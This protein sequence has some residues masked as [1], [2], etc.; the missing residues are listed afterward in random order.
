MPGYI[1]KLPLPIN[2]IPQGLKDVLSDEK[3]DNPKKEVVVTHRYERE[4]Y[5]DNHEC[6]QMIMAV[7][8]EEDSEN[9]SILRES[10]NGVVAYSV[11]DCRVKGGARE[12]N[13]SVSGNGYIVA[14][15]GDGLHYSFFLAEDVWMILGLKPRLIGDSGQK[16]IFDNPS[17]P[18]YGVVQGD[19]SSEYYFGSNK[20]IK[21]TMQNEYLRKYLWMKGCVGARAFYYEKYIQRTT[22]VVELLAGTEHYKFQEPWI[23]LDIVDQGDR[24]IMQVWGT[25]QS[26]QPELCEE[27]DIDSLTWPGHT[28]P[29]T[30]AKASDIRLREF[31]YIDDSFLT[32]YEK[33]NSFDAIPYYD[34]TSYRIDPSYGGQWSFRD[35]IRIGRNIVRIPFY[36]L[37][38][39]IPDKE[40]YHVYDYAVDPSV[41]DAEKEKEEHTVSKTYRFLE[42]LIKLNE[43]LVLLG[44]VVGVALSES[45]ISEFNRQDFEAE[46]LQKYP[47][48]QK[49]SH[50][51]RRDMQE[52]DF[53]SRC[54]T[55]NEILNKIKV[56]NLKKLLVAMGIA[57]KEINNFQALK[58]LQGILNFSEALLEYGED[59]SAFSYASNFSDLNTRNEKLASLFINNDL[60]NAEAHEA[61]NKSIEHLANIGFDS[62]TLKSGYS[63]ALDFV[64]DS[65]IDSLSYLN[66]KLKGALSNQ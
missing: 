46:G 49:L 55:I 57:K 24:V 38:R 66:Y 2:Q 3:V 31:A 21:W 63:Q 36:E 42:E 39:G 29:M 23:E 8:P 50:V 20:D 58:L 22:E 14:S 17:L 41:I 47:V 59:A 4:L 19:V 51:A 35:C 5:Q 1:D 10:S 25:V 6:L 7:V 34:G 48:L 9:L 32:R 37:Y 40:V 44:Q 33:D 27:L 54:K 65:V 60:R 13:L 61:V 15:W 30:R 11:P 28:D 62:A 45:D 64:F 16:V 12:Y 26:V 43:N 53:L 56:G 18:D 52:H